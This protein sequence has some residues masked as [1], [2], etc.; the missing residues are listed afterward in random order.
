MGKIEKTE[1]SRRVLITIGADD[2]AMI[3]E[4]RR[5]QADPPNFSE[6]MRELARIGA[7]SEAKKK[8]A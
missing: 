5:K 2:E 3:N 6:A 1:A 8:A 4:W 7:K